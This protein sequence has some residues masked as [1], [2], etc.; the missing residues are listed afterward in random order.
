[1][2]V[3]EAS[4]SVGSFEFSLFRQRFSNYDRQPLWESHG[5]T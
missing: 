2:K 5:S 3:L 1:V 4:L